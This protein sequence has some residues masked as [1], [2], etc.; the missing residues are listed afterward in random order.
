[1]SRCTGPGRILILTCILMFGL[2]A[3][4][5]TA[6]VVH[7]NNGRSLEGVILEE[8]A[9]RVI[10]Q[11]P[12]GEIGMPRSSISRIERGQST[13]REYLDR[14]QELKLRP[15]TAADWLELALWARGQRLDH[16]YREATLVAAR[17]DPGLPALAPVMRDL[18]FEYE[19]NL[20]LWVPYEQYMLRRGYVR[21]GDRWLSPVEAAE[22][23]RDME[24]ARVARADRERRDQLARALEMLMLAQ[25]AQAEEE[26]QMRRESRPVSYGIPLWG[27]YPVLVTPPVYHPG[28]PLRPLPHRPKDGHRSGRYERGRSYPGDIVHRPPGS[29]IPVEVPKSHRGS[30]QPPPDPQ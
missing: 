23:R 30:F 12:F 11:L 6:D 10:L 4:T 13:L 20:G 18:G 15:G 25:I 16:S 27:G 9:E 28:P 17:L 24:A 5:S 29:L 1:M 8:S 21:S 3:T 7:L 2:Q 26:R 19:V 22:L 14:S